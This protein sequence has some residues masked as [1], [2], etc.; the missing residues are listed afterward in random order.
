[1]CTNDESTSRIVTRLH[2]FLVE[3]QCAL[4]RCHS[5]VQSA[6]CLKDGTLVGMVGTLFFVNR[7][8]T[9]DGLGGDLMPSALIGDRPEQI[10]A[11]CMAG[12]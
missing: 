1:M 8:R 11:V 5:L 4:I 2:W 12:I 3:S 7:N 9:A 10:Q 6:L